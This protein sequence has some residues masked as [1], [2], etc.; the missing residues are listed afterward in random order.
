MRPNPLV[1][2]PKPLIRPAAITPTAATYPLTCFRFTLIAVTN[3]VFISGAKL[4]PAKLRRMSGCDEYRR[5]A[6]HLRKLY[7]DNPA[8]LQRNLQQLSR[9]HDL[10]SAAR[11][12]ISPRPKSN[13]P[14]SPVPHYASR[15]PGS[16]YAGTVPEGS[17]AIVDW[18]ADRVAANL[19]GPAQILHYSRRLSLLKDAARLGIGR[20]PANLMIATL[21]HERRQSPLAPREPVPHPNPLPRLLIAAV[22]IAIQT[23]IAWAA[24]LA[25]HPR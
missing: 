14:V 15:A 16:V 20:F 4:R 22:V 23:L 3:A 19:D 12:Q 1:P 21:Q 7:A 24:W 6:R 5:E 2:P 10:R 8:R 25:I 11:S 13:A 17:R 18:F 9:Q